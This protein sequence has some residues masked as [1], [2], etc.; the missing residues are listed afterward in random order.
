MPL[1]HWPAMPRRS[2]GVRKNEQIRSKITKM[3]WWNISGITSSHVFRIYGVPMVHGWLTW[4]MTHEWRRHCVWC[5]VWETD[6]C[7][8]MA[9]VA[10][11]QR[12]SHVCA[13]INA[14]LWRLAGLCTCVQ[15][16]GCAH[17]EPR[18]HIIIPPLHRRWKGGI[19]DSPWCLS[20]RLSV[21]PS[22]CRQGFRNFSRKL[23]A[24]FISSLGFI[25]MG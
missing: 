2:Y 16:M 23:L 6:H 15:R 24:Q 12:T 8:S 17:A 22:V 9:Q 10:R 4:R 1:F 3:V 11:A 18:I 14:I 25:L 7:V 19:L 5:S 20:V 21:R 13:A